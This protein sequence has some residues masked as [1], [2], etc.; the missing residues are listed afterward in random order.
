MTYHSLTGIRAWIIK[1]GFFT[2]KLLYYPRNLAR[3]IHLMSTHTDNNIKNNFKHH[4]VISIMTNTA[5]P[6]QQPW[7][8]LVVQKQS[9]CTGAKQSPA[10]L[11]PLGRE[12]RSYVGEKF[13]I[14][15]L[16]NERVKYTTDLARLSTSNPVLAF[17]LTVVMFSIA[18]IPP[19]AGFYSKAFLMFAA[20]GSANYVIAIIGVGMSVVS[21]FYYLRIIKIMYFESLTSPGQASKVRSTTSMLSFMQINK[22]ISLVC[23]ITLAFLLFFSL[24]PK[25][26]FLVTQKAALLLS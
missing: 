1:K 18:G 17:T 9:F 25:P 12:N 3:I 2:K 7:Q 22:E 16:V 19:L 23:A 21:A 5:I 4:S 11:V 15:A 20:I 26:V 6:A 14:P 8:K 10:T 24:H 13:A